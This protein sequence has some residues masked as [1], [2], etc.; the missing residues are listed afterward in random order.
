[1]SIAGK[2]RLSSSLEDY[3]EAILLLIRRG[4]VARVRDIAQQT[5][6]A[7]SSVTAALKTLSGR[8]LVNYDPYQ[9]I[10]LTE[11]G[12]AIAEQIHHRHEIL[13]RFMTDVLGLDGETAEANACR[14][15][16]ATDDVALERLTKFAEFIRRCPRAGGDWIDNF[17]RYCMG[18]YDPARC[19]QCI[20]C[21]DPP[22][23][24]KDSSQDISEGVKD[25]R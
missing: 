13:R 11:E 4:R 10:T 17:L 24:S 7:M 5:K 14:M 8:G 3:L 16:H 21:I 20:S 25:G 19:R 1:M 9:V 22:E 23:D 18:K 6:V 2:K 12:R 15:E